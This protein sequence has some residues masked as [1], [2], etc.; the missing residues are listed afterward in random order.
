MPLINRKDWINTLKHIHATHAS[1]HHTQQMIIDD[2]ATK[3]IQCRTL[4]AFFQARS[5][6][7]YCY[8]NT[9]ILRYGKDRKTIEADLPIMEDHLKF[10][11][12]LAEHD[13]NIDEDGDMFANMSVNVLFHDL[14]YCVQRMRNALQGDFS[15]G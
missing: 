5:M 8:G 3:D 6:V 2:N 12:G 11:S 4:K 15:D 9:Q 1:A 10:F 7:D 13:K 14:E